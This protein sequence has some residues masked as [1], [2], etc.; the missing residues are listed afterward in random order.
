MI[1]RCPGQVIGADVVEL[2]PERDIN[3][4]TANVAARLV[5]ELAAKIAAERA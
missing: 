2:N 3:L 1:A 5:K 4:L